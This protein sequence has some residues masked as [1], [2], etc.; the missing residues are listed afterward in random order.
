MWFVGH[1]YLKQYFSDVHLSQSGKLVMKMFEKIHDLVE[2]PK[3]IVFLLI[4]EVES[5][6]QVI[7]YNY[8]YN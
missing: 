5:L 2:D 1:K 8:N 6:A 4:D 3:C 7:K